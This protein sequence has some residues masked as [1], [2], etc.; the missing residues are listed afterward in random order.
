MIQIYFMSISLAFAINSALLS[1]G[2]TDGSK[3]D[4]DTKGAKVGLFL[5]IMAGVVLLRPIALKVMYGM[6]YEPYGRVEDYNDTYGE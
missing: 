2:T 6:L 5:I 1:A 3:S 4:F